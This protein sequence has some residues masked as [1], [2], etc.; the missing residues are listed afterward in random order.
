MSFKSSVTEEGIIYTSQGDGTIDSQMYYIYEEKKEWF[1]V[2]VASI[3]SAGKYDSE[4]TT[5]TNVLNISNKY[6]NLIYFYIIVNL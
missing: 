2:K 4:N 6:D 3:P 1:L 5:I